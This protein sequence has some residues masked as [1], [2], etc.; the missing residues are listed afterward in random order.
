MGGCD[1]IFPH[2]ALF[3]TSMN[4]PA[5][6]VNMKALALITWTDTHAHVRVGMGAPV[7]KPVGHCSA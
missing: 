2:A 7:A 1:H 3:Q 6:L 4:V 5:T